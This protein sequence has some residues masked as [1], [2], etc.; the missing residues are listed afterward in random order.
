MA[1]MEASPVPQPKEGEEEKHDQLPEKMTKA[2]PPEI[3]LRPFQLSDVDDFM[4]WATDDRVSQFCSWDTYT[5][6]DD[7]LRHMTED[8]LP[9]PFFRA[10]CVDGRPVGSISVTLNPGKNDQCRGELGY[11]L[12]SDYWGRGI[13]LRGVKMAVASVFQEVPGLGRVEAVVDVENVASQRVMEKAGFLREG[14]LRKYFLMKGRVRDAV[15]YSFLSPDPVPSYLM[16]AF[17]S[18]VR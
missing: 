8:V 2:A 6:R 5:S 16:L 3:S 10:I 1:A 17:L 11:V 14:V 4:A 7:V 12:A 9:H 18:D 13:V 15:I